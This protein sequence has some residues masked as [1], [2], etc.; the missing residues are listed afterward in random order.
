[1]TGSPLTLINSAVDADRNGLFFDRLPAGHYCGAGVNAFCAD[2]DGRRNGAFGPSFKQADLKFAYRLKPLRQDTI[3]I[4]VELFNLMNTAN[5]ANPGAG[6]ANYGQVTDQ[7]LS[8][9]ELVLTR[10]QE[11]A[12]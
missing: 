5:F 9:L 12:R 4:N 1:M 3:D 11:V 10:A 7:R 6:A 2:F 8:D